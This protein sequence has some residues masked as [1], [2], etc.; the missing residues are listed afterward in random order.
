MY[1]GI[2]LYGGRA[3]FVLASSGHIAG[4]VNPPAAGR[5][6]YRTNPK[7]PAKPQ[8]WLKGS[9]ERD[10]SWWPDWNK[11]IGRYVGG[12]APAREPGAGP[13]QAIEDAPGSYVGVRSEP[14]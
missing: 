13:L 6:S 7:T 14:G 1:A 9:T 4:V 12:E 2:R 3:R 8:A 5:Y 11:W 10:G